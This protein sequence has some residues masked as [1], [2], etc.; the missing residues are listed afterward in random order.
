MTNMK[1][2]RGSAATLTYLEPREAE[3]LAAVPTQ[4][5]SA[6]G[7]RLVSDCKVQ[8]YRGGSWLYNAKL[9]AEKDGDESVRGFSFER[10]G[11]RLT[12]DSEAK[13]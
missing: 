5:G 4:T 12:H 9:A 3:S 8:H 7:L 13:R 1:R 11:I 10:L 6:L 2:A